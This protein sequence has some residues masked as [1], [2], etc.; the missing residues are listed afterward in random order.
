[1][2]PVQ[3][4][5]CFVVTLIG[6]VSVCPDAFGQLTN[7]RVFFGL[8]TPQPRQV[9]L[10]QWQQNAE[11]NY[12]VLN[13]ETLETTVK[14]SPVDQIRPLPWASVLQAA[15]QTAYGRAMQTEQQRDANLQDAGIERLIPPS[16]ASA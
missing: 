13:P 6:L 10:R 16:G 12:L 4:K 9:V 2:Y 14:V 15:R 8:T 7:Y 11:T 5:L 1:M 3:I